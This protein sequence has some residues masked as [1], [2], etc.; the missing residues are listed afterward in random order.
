MTNGFLVTFYKNK[1]ILNSG[2]CPAHKILTSPG[3]RRVKPASI[4][5]FKQNIFFHN[6]LN[7]HVLSSFKQYTVLI[8]LVDLKLQRE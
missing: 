3:E 8:R 2:Q 7:S 1:V 5:Y 6:I 4:Q